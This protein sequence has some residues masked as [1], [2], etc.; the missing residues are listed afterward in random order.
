MDALQVRHSRG[1][2]D[3]H[4]HPFLIPTN[5]LSHAIRHHST[6]SSVLPCISPWQGLYSSRSKRTRLAEAECVAMR[7]QPGRLPD[8]FVSILSSNQITF[9][10]L[11]STTYQQSFYCYRPK[12]IVITLPQ[13]SEPCLKYSGHCISLTSYSILLR[14]SGLWTR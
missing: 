14:L 1:S 13:H 11:L 8:L 9:I 6:P 7:C 5:R 4:P 10:R 3:I 12:L 2:V